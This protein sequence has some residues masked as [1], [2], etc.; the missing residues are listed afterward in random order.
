MLIHHSIVLENAEIGIAFVQDRKFEWINPKMEAL[1]D[2]EAN[3]IIDAATELFYPSNEDFIKFGKDAYP[4]LSQGK[5]YRKVRQMKRRDNSLFWCNLT[6][7]AV[8]SRNMEEGSIWLLEDVSARIQIE[9]E[10]RKAKDDAETASRAKSEFLAN[11]SHEIRTP[12]NAILGFAEI[13]KGKIRDEQHKQYLTSIH[14]AGKTLMTLINDILDLSKIEA[15]K[16]KLDYEP[17]NPVFVFKEIADVFSQNI[18]DKGLKFFME[19]DMNLPEFLLLD[20]IRLRQILFNLVGNAIKFTESGHV[21]IAVYMLAHKETPD[22]VDF[23]FA[24]EDTGIGIPD[25]QKQTIFNTFEQQS[26]QDHACYGGTGL[27]LA[28]TKRLTEMMGGVISVSGEKGQGS[29]FTVTLKNVQKTEAVDA[30]G[31]NI[32]PSVDSVIFDK[33]VILIA[34]DIKDSRLVLINCLEDYGFGF[35]EAQ[36]GRQAI[37]LA[38]DRHPDLILMDMKMPVTDGREATRI[39]KAHD[40]TKDIPIIA[41][42]AEAMKDAEKEIR[43]LCDGYLRK[44]IKKA[45]LI[46]ELIRFLKHTL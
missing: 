43:A 22:K 15:G 25:E 40:A 38:R 1:F 3:E 41:V 32:D 28:I 11:M 8:D 35:I 7:K 39:I 6:G 31:I 18:S 14:S 26:G 20:E 33:A 30:P 5:I 46:A 37:D 2:Y 42:T 36:D 12:M 23:I 19:T 44:P 13:L 34:D 24:V 21:K 45:D 10:L 29:I 4:I 27:G 9:T 16:M 17:I